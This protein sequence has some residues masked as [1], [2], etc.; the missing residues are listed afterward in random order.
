MQGEKEL[1]RRVAKVEGNSGL[2]LFQ[3]GLED[4]N[5]MSYLM[6]FYGRPGWWNVTSSPP[7]PWKEQ[8]RTHERGWWFSGWRLRC[9]L[10]NLSAVHRTYNG[11]RAKNHLTSTCVL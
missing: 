10:A 7:W 6:Y 9:K 5:V 1:E 8:V 2:L 11:R 3:L 4:M